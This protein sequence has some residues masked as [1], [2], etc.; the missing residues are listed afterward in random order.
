MVF[1][2]SCFGSES[3]CRT[4]LLVDQP[5][6][7]TFFVECGRNRC[8]SDIFPILVISIR[9]E[10]IRDRILKLSK[11]DPNF[12]RFLPPPFLGAGPPKF[13]DL[14]YKTEKPYDHVGK[15][16]SDRPMQLRNFVQKKKKKKTPAVKYTT[17][18]LS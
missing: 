16:R 15:F 1:P 18:R 14:Y 2:K 3:T 9:S 17:I 7:R 11:V 6:S 5:S 13:W 8:R 10:D 12:A 4:V